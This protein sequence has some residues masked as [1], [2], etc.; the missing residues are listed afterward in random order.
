M[1]RVLVALSIRMRFFQSFEALFIGA[2]EAR[3]CSLIGP[4]AYNGIV[5]NYGRSHRDYMNLL[6]YISSGQAKQIQI[7]NE[8]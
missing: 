8:I 4:Q 3:P 1:H 2:K 6:G 7:V 5:V